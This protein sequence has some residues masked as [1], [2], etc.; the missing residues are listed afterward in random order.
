MNFE[1]SEFFY[2]YTRKQA[3]EDGV[4]IDV[5]DQAKA[6]GFKI[7]VAVTDHLYNGYVVPSKELEEEGQSVEG[8]LHDLFMMTQAAAANRWKDNRVYYEVLFKTQP[9]TLQTVRCLA[10]VG[11]GD[12]GEPV[13]TIMLPEDE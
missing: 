4:L 10:V 12:E 6:S 3:I 5:S 9:R 7:P 1:G 8:R 13:L 2:S 11:P